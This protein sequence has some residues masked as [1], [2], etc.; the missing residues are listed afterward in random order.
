MDTDSTTIFLMAKTDVSSREVVAGLCS[1]VWRN[2]D[3]FVL[4]EKIVCFSCNDLAEKNRFALG[5]TRVDRYSCGGSARTSWD[6]SALDLTMSSRKCGVCAGEESQTELTTL[7][8]AIFILEG[9]SGEY[10]GKSW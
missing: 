8:K 7:G 6:S 5:C 1:P 2:L 4:D 9:V 3:V 10:Y